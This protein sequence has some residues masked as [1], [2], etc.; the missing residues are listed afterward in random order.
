MP[1]IEFGS[2]DDANAFRGE[3]EEHLCP[4]DDRR[5]KVV[6]LVGD[7][8]DRVLDEAAVQAASS[9]DD[10]G[11]RGGQIP[12]E[13]H[14]RD[15]I[16]FSETNVL[17]ARSVK[18]I[19]RE[20]G[21]DDWTAFYD[22]TLTVDEHR[23]VMNRAARDEQGDRLDQ[24]AS[25][26]ER[27]AGVEEALDGQCDHAAD[28]C[29]HGE[30]EACEFLVEG[31]GLSDDQ[32]EAILSEGEGDPAKGELPGPAYGALQG[33]WT[34]FRAGLGEA[35]QAAA[36]INEIRVQFGQDPMAFEELGNREIT[37]EAL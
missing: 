3:H 26:D 11:S 28:H 33:L 9:R 6:T 34:Q 2:R 32:V 16:D 13:D 15:R 21:V 10:R 31:C 8:P 19:A 22:P 4:Y 36:G 20:A 30:A 27:L 37:Q 12:L 29:A 35:K 5:K 24:E 23:E 7:A 14:E 18:G 25:V 17:H 1:E